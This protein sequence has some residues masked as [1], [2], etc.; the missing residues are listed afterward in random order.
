MCWGKRAL[1]WWKFWWTICFRN[2]KNAEDRLRSRIYPRSTLPSSRMF[3]HVLCAPSKYFFWGSLR[4]WSTTRTSPWLNPCCNSRPHWSSWSQC[5]QIYQICSQGSVGKPCCSRFP[6]LKMRSQCSKEDSLAYFTLWTPTPL[7]QSNDYSFYH[8]L[9]YSGFWE[10][11]LKTF[12]GCLAVLRENACSNFY[13]NSNSRISSPDRKN[14]RELQVHWSKKRKEPKEPE[15]EEQ[16]QIPRP[17]G[18][19]PQLRG[20]NKMYL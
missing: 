11:P 10:W 15:R 3:R 16:K 19:T 17:A 5:V 9:R 20:H 14:D 4:T 6:E 2:W 8:N 12:R 18:T 7:G 1:K 13:R